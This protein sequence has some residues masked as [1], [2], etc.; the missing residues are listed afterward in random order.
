[1]PKP[2]GPTPLFWVQKKKITEGRKAG[3]TA[4][5]PPTPQKTAPPPLA[6]GLPFPTE[7]SEENE[8]L[9]TFTDYYGSIPGSA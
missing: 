5:P 7:R 9:L 1:M 6:Q 8:V 2:P 3:C 4:P